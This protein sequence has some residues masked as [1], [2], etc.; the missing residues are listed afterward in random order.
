MSGQVLAWILFHVFVAVML[1]LDL[2]CFHKQCHEIRIREA[3]GWSAFWVILA[4]IFCAGVWKFEGPQ[5][6]MQFLTGYLLEKSLSVDNLFV[7]LLIFSYFK[8]PAA[9]QHKVLFW[10][11]LGALGMRALFI[12]SGVALI[13]RFEWIMY[14]FGAFLVYSGFKLFFESEKEVEPEKNPVVRAFKRIMPI[15]QTY[16]AD[17]LFVRRDNR[18]WATPLLVVLL[19]IETTDVIFAVDSIPAVL[20]VSTDP[21]IVYTSNIFAILGLRSLYFALA[22]V[23]KLFRYLHYGLGAILIFVGIKMLGSHYCHVSTGISLGIIGGMLM[24]SVVLSIILVPRQ[25]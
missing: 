22:G 12:F 24:F 6:G 5:K 1:Y 15:T 3:V 11:I 16:E 7:F 8:V 4:L 2:A 10:G 23:M 13:Q 20:S 21:F 25:P 14:V 17:R 18:W 9:Y 19:V